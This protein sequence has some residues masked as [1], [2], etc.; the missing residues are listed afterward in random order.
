MIQVLGGVVT[1]WRIWNLWS[2]G[3]GINGLGDPYLKSINKYIDIKTY[4]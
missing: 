3:A 4:T 2:V 1:E